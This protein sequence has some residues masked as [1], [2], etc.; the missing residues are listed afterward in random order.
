MDGA[1]APP[2]EKRCNTCGE[3][4]PLSEFYRNCDTKDGLAGL[5]KPCSNRAS[6]AW[7]AAN[8]QRARELELRHAPKKLAHMKARRD[9]DKA[10][11][12]EYYGTCCACCGFTEDLTIDHIN[13]DG[14]EHRK[15]LFGDGRTGT[16]RF[17]RWLISNNFPP[18]F[19][20]LCRSCNSSK[21]RDG[22]CKMHSSA[23]PSHLTTREIRARIAAC[24]DAAYRGTPTV[25]TN[26]GKP[27]AILV[28]Y[29]EWIALQASG[30]PQ[31]PARKAAPQE[32]EVAR[33]F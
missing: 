21:Y 33:L 9:R 1:Y 22:A 29:D 24:V 10:K 8:P 25:I 4:K 5:C 20:T 26:Q 3:V 19:Q 2:A 17:Y 32:N 30:R 31:R 18:G 7:R 27:R 15:E 14:Y 13:G 12:L 6:A 11:V 16:A 28:S 23:Q